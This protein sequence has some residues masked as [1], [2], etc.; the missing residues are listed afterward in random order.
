M[1]LWASEKEV[2]LS[3]NPFLAFT[4][5]QDHLQRGDGKQPCFPFGPKMASERGGCE[6]GSLSSLGDLE[7]QG[8]RSKEVG[9]WV[10]TYNDDYFKI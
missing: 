2:L 5:S 9:P 7:G 4:H 8:R 6:R 1:G 10:G 3:L